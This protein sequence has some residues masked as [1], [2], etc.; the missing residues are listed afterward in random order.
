V[1][2]K[3]INNVAAATPG[4][5]GGVLISGSNAGTTTLGALTVT[6][7]TTHTGNVSM[8]AGLTIT[9]STTN[10]DAVDITGNGTGSGM[11]VKSGSGAT[12]DGVKMISQATAGNGLTLTHNGSSVYDLNAQTTNGLQVNTTAINSVSASSVTTINANQGTTQ[13][14]NFTGTGASAL[15]K[16][17]VDDWN[18][19]AVSSPATAGI[20]DVNVKNWAGTAAAGS[21][22]SP[23]VSVRKNTALANFE[24]LMTDSTAH[25][26][27]TG[28]GTNVTVTRSIDGGAFSAGTLT[29]VTELGNGIYLTG[30]AAADLNGGVITLQATASGCD[31]TFVT[32]VTAQ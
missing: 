24:F 22:G 4:A 17:D 7:A 27:K 15:V 29:S 9:Q 21:N 12:G 3:N 31:T 16:V 20:P 26:P 6:G 14:L 32:L 19:T 5:S 2:V 11:V 25:A 1:N 23:P 13:P 10:A 28:L 18:G 30:F 8:A